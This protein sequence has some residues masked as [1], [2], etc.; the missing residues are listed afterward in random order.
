MVWRAL[1]APHS[2]YQT[3][4]V[5]LLI[6][7]LHVQSCWL[8]LVWIAVGVDVDVAAGVE[9]LRDAPR[10]NGFVRSALETGGV[11]RNADTVRVS[12]AILRRCRRPRSRR[13]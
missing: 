4:F 3:F 6:R 10:T 12:R 7:C 1:V 13:R 9:N 2:L 11:V 5:L 8:W